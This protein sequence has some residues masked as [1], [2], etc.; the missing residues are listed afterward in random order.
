MAD[1]MNKN[2]LAGDTEDTDE[3]EDV[4]VYTLTDED[5]NEKDFELIG[6]CTLDDATYYALTELDDDG[7]QV[8][9][10]YVILRL[11]DEDCVRNIGICYK[12]GHRGKDTIRKF[13]NMFQNRK[14]E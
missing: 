8:S 4:E 7:N 5:G 11:E 14:K 10:E 9:D 13:V 2:P 12:V 6:K 3:L 1:D